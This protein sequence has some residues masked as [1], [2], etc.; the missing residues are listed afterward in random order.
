[1]G[2]YA[3][4]FY[5]LVSRPIMIHPNIAPKNGPNKEIDIANIKIINANFGNIKN[6]NSPNINNSMILPPYLLI[7]NNA[8][9]ISMSIIIPIKNGPNNDT[10]T[11][12]TNN[13]KIVI[14]NKCLFFHI[15]KSIIKHINAH[16]MIISFFNLDYCK[17]SCL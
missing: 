10:S 14:N 3:P 1:M 12:K 2:L 13:G 8:H 7:S 5:F 15:I 9:I 11:I 6:N 17:C 4:Y 16:I